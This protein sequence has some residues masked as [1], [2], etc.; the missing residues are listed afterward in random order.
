LFY[1]GSFEELAAKNS[2]FLFE[3]RVDLFVSR[4]KGFADIRAFEKDSFGS[5]A[6]CV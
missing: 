2:E 1:R 4:L 5:V 3:Q 6:A